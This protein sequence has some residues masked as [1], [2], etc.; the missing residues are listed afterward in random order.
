M[1]KLGIFGGTFNPIHIGHINI[2]KQFVQQMDLERVLVI[3]DRI[4][5][6]KEV[7]GLISAQERYEMCT[8]ACEDY[9]FLEPCALEVNKSGRSYT[10]ET[11]ELLRRQYP[12]CQFFLLMGSDM[13]MTLEEWYRFDDIIKMAV[14]C[15]GSRD[16][17][18]S[19]KMQETKDHLE[20]L[21]AQVHICNIDVMP[22]SSTLIRQM[23]R[24]GVDVAHLLPPRVNHYVHQN[25][26][27]REG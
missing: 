7:P 25:Q 15:A 27:Y 21:G 16:F 3:P 8:L 22:I 10:I 18:I 23:I 24:H 13:F 2:A 26:L 14:I 19:E 12:D 1:K 9:D 20:S 11:L 6:H 17:N 4:P 5:P